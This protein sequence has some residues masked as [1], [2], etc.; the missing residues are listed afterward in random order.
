MATALWLT[1]RLIGRPTI[2][3]AAWLGARMLAENGRKL[4]VVM[5][6]HGTDITLVGRAPSFQPVVKFLLG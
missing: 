4:R 3:A 6:L 2:A 1:Y 5:T